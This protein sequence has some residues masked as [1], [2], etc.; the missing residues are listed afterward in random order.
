MLAEWDD[1]AKLALIVDNQRFCAD[2]LTSGNM[3]NGCKFA[4]GGD[5]AACVKSSLLCFRA[6]AD[7]GGGCSFSCDAGVAP[8]R[9]SR[10]REQAN[11]RERA[12]VWISFFSRR[13]RRANFA[14]SGFYF[15]W[16]FQLANDAL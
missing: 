13:A 1:V 3:E 7:R 8:R 10:A 4:D 5:D 14:T 9:D 12:C 16:H 11:C 6:V 15:P 2:D